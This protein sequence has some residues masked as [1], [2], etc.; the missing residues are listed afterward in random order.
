MCV[1]KVTMFSNRIAK[2]F[3]L[4]GVVIHVAKKNYYAVKKGIETGVFTTW[5]ECKK[6]TH[7]YP[8]AEYQKFSSEEQAIKYLEKDESQKVEKLIEN[9]VNLD[10]IAYVDGSFNSASSEYSYGAV[11][12][13]EGEQ[14]HFSEKFND[15]ELVSMRNV[16]GEI[17]GAEKAMN[18]AME[19]GANSLAIYYDYEGIEKWCT[20]EWKAKKEGTIEYKQYYNEVKNVVDIQFI[21]VKSHSGNEWNELADKLAKEV[22]LQSTE[23]GISVDTIPE[24]KK[25]IGIYI[26]SEMLEE[27]I[28]NA[29]FSEWQDFEMIS[30]EEV[31]N[32]QRYCFEVD[33]KQCYLDF[34]YSTNKGTFTMNPI[35]KHQDISLRLKELIIEQSEYKDMGVSKSYTFNI[36]QEWALKLVKFLSGLE[37]IK[38]KE[39]VIESQK[40]QQYRFISAIGDRLN[41]NVYL[42]NK[43]VLQGK[44]AYLYSEA[45][46]FLSY[47]PE[48]SIN[49]V[50]EA[51]NSFHEVNIKVQ[52]T[53]DELQRLMPNT[54]GNIDDTL[55]KILSPTISLKKVGMELEDYS[56]YVFPA[57][58]ALEGYLLYIFSMEDIEISHKRGK[59]YGSHYRHVT[60]NDTHKLKKQT[61][62]AL[63]N[64]KSIDVLEEVYNYLRKNRHTLFHAEQIFFMTRILEDKIEA[65]QIINEVIDMIERTYTDLKV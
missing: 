5:E 64:K 60:S 28:K 6:N 9:P 63:S 50:V 30:F 61:A 56:C 1:L 42:T 48:I 52:D 33:E 34:Y 51:N 59:Q 62:E 27:A 38:V 17:K 14:L 47:C 21:K 29:G 46:S 19:K 39:K 44:P 25:N 49:D 15:S 22:F 11:I 55:F 20:G 8:G 31:G 23:E 16:A 3:A 65:D 7:G 37:E 12:F 53:R 26:E 10:V 54:Y 43:V 13:F 45:L 18:F 4:M 32:A 35:G 41:I 2:M 40:L 36:G 24:K 58:R 57:L